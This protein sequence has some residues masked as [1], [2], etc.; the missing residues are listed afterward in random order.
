[1]HFF[2]VIQQRCSVRAFGPKPLLDEQL[3]QILNSANRAPSAGNLQA[4][5]IYVVFNQQVRVELARAALGQD[6]ITQAPVVLVFCA[7]PDRSAWRYRKRGETLFALQDAT[8]ACSFAM[9]AATD[10]GLGCVWVGA[11]DDKGVQ[12]AIKAPRNH[13]PIAILPIGYP[14]EPPSPSRRRELD[15]LVH[16]VN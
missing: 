1:M 8:I 6:F 9:L 7:H 14:A 16:K 15:S 13:L 11:F 12:S 4:Y 5:E 2:D 10:L 3:Q